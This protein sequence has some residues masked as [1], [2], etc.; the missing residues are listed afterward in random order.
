MLYVESIITTFPSTSESQKDAR[1]KRKYI[2]ASKKSSKRTTSSLPV[3][4]FSFEDE[5]MSGTHSELQTQ[6]AHASLE[7][8]QILLQ[9]RNCLI[10]GKEKIHPSGSQNESLCE[11]GSL[12]SDDQVSI[13]GLFTLVRI[14][15]LNYRVFLYWI[16]I[17]NLL[18]ISVEIWNSYSSWCV[19]R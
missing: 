4:R 6:S 5:H 19:S 10:I 9:K 8:R 16:I 12:S 7:R 18:Y 1:F 2:L 17:C 14:F 3:R 11:P 13:S 15:D